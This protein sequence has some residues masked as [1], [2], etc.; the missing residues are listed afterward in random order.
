M[1]AGLNEA[2][3]A[4]YTRRSGAANSGAARPPFYSCTT[5]HFQLGCVMLKPVV[6]EFRPDDDGTSPSLDVLLESGAFSALEDACLACAG[7]AAVHASIEPDE[8]LLKQED[9]EQLALHSERRLAAGRPPSNALPPSAPLV[10]R[11]GEVLGASLR[12]A[13]PRCTNCRG[14]SDEAVPSRR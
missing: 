6:S 14:A 1:I 10:R 7:L 8:N 5:A 12:C 2:I 3:A 11:W 4:H 9:L 13:N